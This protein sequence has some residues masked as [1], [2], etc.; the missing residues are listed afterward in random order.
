MKYKVCALNELIS[1]PYNPP[2][3]TTKG[4]NSLS[5]KHT[6]E[7]VITTYRSSQ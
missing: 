1:S 3:R 4:M 7:W 6:R 5:N 2:T